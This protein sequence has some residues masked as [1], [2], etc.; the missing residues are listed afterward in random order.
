MITLN[1]DEV[2]ERTYNAK[3]G[4][5]VRYGLGQGF[6]YCK[7]F[8][9]EA[10][11]HATN[12][13][14]SEKKATDAVAGIEQTKT[15]A[16]QAVQNAQ[17]TATN[18]VQQAQR[19]ATTAVTTKQTEAVQAVDDERDAALQ[20]VADST[21][22]AQTA[23]SKAAASEQAAQASKEAAATSA[24][25]AESSAT[26][27]SGSASA[28]AT[29]ESNAASSAQSS[30][31][32]A[33]RAEAA[34]DLAGT[35]A[36][37]DKTL[38]TENAPADA[39]AVGDYILDS[40]GNVIFYSKAAVDE[41]LAGKLDIKPTS[42]EGLG[43]GLEIDGAGKLGTSFYNRG[44]VADANEAKNPGWYSIF[45]DATNAPLA[46]A[47]QILSFSSAGYIWPCQ[48]FLSSSTSGIHFRTFD[49]ANWG[50]WMAAGIVASGSN[51]VRF[52]DGTQICWGH[53]VFGQLNANSPT[54]GKINFAVPFANTD[55]AVVSLQ[56]GDV[57][58]TNYIAINL[59]DKT[60]T[61][62]N[63]SLYNSKD[64]ANNAGVIHD[65]I[66][67]GRWK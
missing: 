51:Y 46:D 50:A 21:K 48:I 67:I 43:A 31:T 66:V 11:G 25:A 1:F 10:Q 28:A 64:Y 7:Q 27:A 4:V 8:A 65:C 2:L 23:A 18:A 35:R 44:H 20:Q 33:D 24:G 14:A 63:E 30:K 9:D 6:E 34:A 39:K 47:G 52:G 42:A 36:N 61:Y 19:T 38:K 13:K 26:A 40:E 3:K 60:T 59:V 56:T 41:L 62:A 5:D 49:G 54:Y 22:A 57:G 37:T 32:D 53:I 15:D 58:G 29:S 55:Y 16:V 45:A 17:T 12:A